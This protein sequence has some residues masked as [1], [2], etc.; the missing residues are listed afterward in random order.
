MKYIEPPAHLNSKV[1]RV[2]LMKKTTVIDKWL[3]R[4]IFFSSS[5]RLFIRVIRGAN[6]RDYWFLANDNIISYCEKRVDFG[7]WK[8]W[9][10]R[11]WD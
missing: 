1:A 10:L 4:S 5:N 9:E 2:A 11:L 6:R 3:F 8:G 7:V